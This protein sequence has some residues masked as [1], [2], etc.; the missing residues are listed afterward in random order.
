MCNRLPLGLALDNQL[1][2][3]AHDEVEP[4]LRRE[5]IPVHCIYK[6][7]GQVRHAVVR[8]RSH[9]LVQRGRVLRR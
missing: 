7:N 3:Q 6:D 8:Q 9:P 4:S 5:L 2:G 1:V